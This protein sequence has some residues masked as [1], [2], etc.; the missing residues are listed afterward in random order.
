MID[1]LKR[2]LITDLSQLKGNGDI[3]KTIERIDWSKCGPSANHVSFLQK[4]IELRAMQKINVQYNIPSVNA[5]HGGWRV[6]H[7]YPSPNPSYN[8]APNPPPKPM[9]RYGR[10]RRGGRGSG[11]GGR[12]GGSRG[13]G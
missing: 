4:V 3:C 12:R 2:L 1:E 5:N 11:R 6:S 9:N 10:R 13:R 8:A 7:C